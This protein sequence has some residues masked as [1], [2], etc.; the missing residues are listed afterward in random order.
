MKLANFVVTM[1]AASVRKPFAT[2]LTTAQIIA[3]KETAR[4]HKVR[5]LYFEVEV[6]SYKLINMFINIFIYLGYISV[7]KQTNA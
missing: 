5:I 6:V 2:T 7:N 3:T 1:D 4:I